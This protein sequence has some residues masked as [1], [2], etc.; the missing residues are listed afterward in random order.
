ME[1]EKDW[2][3]WSGNNVFA[4]VLTGTVFGVAKSYYITYPPNQGRAAFSSKNR[5]RKYFII[6]IYYI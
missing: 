4:G 3:A 1:E 6:L 2:V 5:E